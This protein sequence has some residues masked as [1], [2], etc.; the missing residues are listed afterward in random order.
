[1]DA[2]A[3]GG[4]GDAA[5]ADGAIPTPTVARS[6]GS[7]ADGGASAT[8]PTPAIPAGAGAGGGGRAGTVLTPT[9]GAG[10]AMRV[11]VPSAGGGGLD[12]LVGEH[13]GR[14][15]TYTIYDTETGAVEVLPNASEHMGGT[16]LPAEHLARAGVD[17]V[18]CSGIGRRAVELLESHGIEVVTG[19]SGTVG[20]AIR[21]WKEGRLG[22]A[23]PCDHGGN[24]DH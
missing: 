23:V 3:A 10:E 15:P 7:P 16:G 19:A 5:G 8:P 20:E 9:L 14:S 4:A 21:A 18:I 13:F 24:C 2:D 1:M 11:C 22:G 12:D 17:V 6:P